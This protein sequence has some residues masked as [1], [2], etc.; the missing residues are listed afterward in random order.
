MDIIN[1]YL[2]FRRDGNY[3]VIFISSLEETEII[4]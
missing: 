3:K 2:F 1:F 4:K